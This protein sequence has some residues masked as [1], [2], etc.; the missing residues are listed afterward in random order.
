M[1]L[2]IFSLSCTSHESHQLEDLDVRTQKSSHKKLVLKKNPSPKEVFQWQRLFMPAPND[3]QLKKLDQQTENQ[4]HNPTLKRSRALRSLGKISDSINS[5]RELLRSDDSNIEAMIEIAQLFLIKGQIE[6]AANYL[7]DAY[8]KIKRIEYPNQ[9]LT[10]KYRYTLALTLLNRGQLKEGRP[11]L[12]NLIAQNPSFTPG[13]LALADSYMKNQHYK[14][15]KFILQRGLDN[16]PKNE[17]LENGIGVI[18]AQEGQMQLA[19]K[20]FNSILNHQ[21]LHVPALINR[22]NI[23]IMMKEYKRAEL[24]L[25][26]A[27]QQ[28]PSHPNIFNSLGL[29]YQQ[30]GRIKE[31]QSA[32]TKALDITPE[33]SFTRYNLAVLFAKHLKDT[34]ESLQLF[35]EVLQSSDLNPKLK[36]LASIQIEGLRESRLRSVSN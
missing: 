17:D 32:Y 35:Y 10:F 3:Q 2:M 25:K 19:S 36:E 1:V 9:K 28:N 11:I 34:N 23:A 7:S 21:P 16:N 31:A 14:L 33:N 18:H 15:A 30:T 27:L 4:D 26:K 8:L 20:Y 22:A 29:L 6:L 13:Y 12:A 24:D 5:Y